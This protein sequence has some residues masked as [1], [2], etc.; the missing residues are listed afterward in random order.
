MGRQ[1]ETLAHIDIFR[2]LTMAASIMFLL[3]FIVRRNDPKAAGEV[4]VG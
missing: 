1:V 3:S 4:A 2:V